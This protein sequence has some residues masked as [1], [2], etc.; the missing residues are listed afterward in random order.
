[1]IPKVIH[2][3]WFGGKPLPDLE[4]KCIESWKKFCPDY[5]IKEWNENNFDLT[6]CNYVKEAYQA[7]KWAF[8]SDYARFKILY[9]YGGLYFDTDVELIRPINDIV[10]RG[11]FMGCEASE[12]K[13][14]KVAPGLGLAAN[15]GLGLYKKILDAYEK[16]HFVKPDGYADNTTIVQF[17]TGI[18]CEYGL[19]NTHKIQ[20]IEEIYIYPE[21]YFC[22]LNYYTGQLCI[23]ENTRSIHHY[24]GSWLSPREEK[25]RELELKIGKKFGT[26][27]LGRLKRS[28]LWRTVTYAYR[29]GISKTVERIKFENSGAER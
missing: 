8:V 28:V 2:Y 10:E 19:K 16:R 14:K 9:E 7:K 12:M 15:P 1:M 3:C 6:C 13:D 4:V 25:C 24:T 18:L 26:P 22:P 5:E 23:T 11:A 17:V 27:F 29:Y 20:D 21:E